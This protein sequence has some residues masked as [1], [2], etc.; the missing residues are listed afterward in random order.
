MYSVTFFN[1]RPG[2]ARPPI[3]KHSLSRWGWRSFFFGIPNTARIWPSTLS[4]FQHVDTHVRRPSYRQGRRYSPS[5]LHPSD[6]TPPVTQTGPT[7]RRAGRL[8]H[9]TSTQLPWNHSL[10]APLPF[11][12]LP[13]KCLPFTKSTLYQI[14]PSPNP[15]FTRPT[16]CQSVST[17]I[18]WRG[19]RSRNCY[20][21]II[22]KGSHDTGT[23]Q[24]AGSL[25]GYSLKVS[26]CMCMGMSHR[27]VHS[28]MF[29][30][31]GPCQEWF[32]SRPACY[33]YENDP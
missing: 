23:F 31:Y 30:S 24:M 4:I 32:L 22:L 29:Q 28:R 15:P 17:T 25:K 5:S 3:C 11:N 26:H 19:T 16:P 13:L 12:T 1:S 9:F 27:M 21:G 6:T 33:M 14:H 8:N 2:V 10:S 7:G 20:R 18:R